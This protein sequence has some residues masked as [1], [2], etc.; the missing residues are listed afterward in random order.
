MSLQELLASLEKGIAGN[1]P[2][3]ISLSI[4]FFLFEIPVHLLLKLK[5]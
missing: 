5:S 2:S 3:P 1:F 4:A